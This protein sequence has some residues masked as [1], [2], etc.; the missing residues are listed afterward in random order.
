M[1]EGNLAHD[2]TVSYVM[3]AYT[4][5]DLGQAPETVMSRTHQGTSSQQWKRIDLT[6]IQSRNLW[7][8]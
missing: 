4:S 1:Y 5:T 2:V 7:S 8:L 3:V 6:G